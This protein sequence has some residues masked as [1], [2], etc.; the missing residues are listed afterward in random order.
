MT[1]M[2]RKNPFMDKSRLDRFPRSENGVLAFLQSLE[3]D[4]GEQE[5]QDLLHYHFKIKQ[6]D[7]E[8]KKVQQLLKYFDSMAQAELLELPLDYKTHREV[9]FRNNLMRTDTGKG[10]DL[11]EKIK[12]QVA[13]QLSADPNAAQKSQMFAPHDTLL[14]EGFRLGTTNTKGTPQLQLELENDPTLA[15]LVK[16]FYQKYTLLYCDQ[17]EAVKAKTMKVQLNLP[18]GSMVSLTRHELD[19]QATNYRKAL[20]SF[21]QISGHLS[22][23]TRNLIWETKDFSVFLQPTPNPKLP[24]SQLFPQTLLALSR[25]LSG[26]PATDEE[27]CAALTAK[28][29][30]LYN[31]WIRLKSAQPMGIIF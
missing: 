9:N 6:S 7:P 17:D 19:T 25:N 20:H 24:A 23:E 1:D 11:G 4:L 21:A 18:Q 12:G 27:I 15:A 14:A 29:S 31:L 3:L 13:Q 28:H 5:T 8:E 26:H 30:E 22:S 16:S 2:L 10:K